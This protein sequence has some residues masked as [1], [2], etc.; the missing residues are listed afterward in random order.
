VKQTGVPIKMTETPGR[1]RQRA[2]ILGEHTEE[3]M[4]EAGYKSSEIAALKRDK[5][6][7]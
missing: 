5:V 7:G 6:V 1:I 4:A 3:I 2:A